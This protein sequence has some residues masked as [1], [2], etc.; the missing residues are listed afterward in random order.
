MK[1]NFKPILIALLIVIFLTA[2][3]V[4]LYRENIW[5]YLTAESEAVLEITTYSP[6][7][8]AS[9]TIDVELLKSPVLISLENKVVDF[10]YEDVCVRPKTVIKTSEGTIVQQAPE[11]VVGNKL[12]FASEDK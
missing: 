4:F 8:P 6:V 3:L 10:N 2:A 5:D 12:P 1:N 7:I 11:C 9:E